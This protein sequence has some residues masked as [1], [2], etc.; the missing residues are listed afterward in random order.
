MFAKGLCEVLLVCGAYFVPV[1][2]FSFIARCLWWEGH[3]TFPVVPYIVTVKGKMSE[4]TLQPR[5]RSIVTPVQ[6]LNDFIFQGLHRSETRL[7][8]I[9]R[10]SLSTTLLGLRFTG[11]SACHGLCKEKPTWVALPRES[12]ALLCFLCLRSLPCSAHRC[13]NPCFFQPCFLFPFAFLRGSPSLWLLL[14]L[15]P[16]PQLLNYTA[17]TGTYTI[18]NSSAPAASRSASPGA[19]ERLAPGTGRALG[20]LGGGD[21]TLIPPKWPPEQLPRDL[22][23][24]PSG[25]RGPVAVML[26][27]RSN[28]GKRKAAAGD[29]W[30]WGELLQ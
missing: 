20:S 18:K 27:F 19:A 2:W 13:L 10:T 17:P 1:H 4:K 21:G 25:P 14:F 22:P 3:N 26:V 9:P 7:M 24:P 28:D 30:K 16:F 15:A 23:Y 6:A 8:R 29:I 5:S 11:K 12:A